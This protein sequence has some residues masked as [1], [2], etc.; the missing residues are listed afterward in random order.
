[1]ALKDLKR[2]TT[3][4]IGTSLDSEW[5]SN[6]NSDNFLGLK[7]NRIYYN[8]L[9]SNLDEIWKRFLYLHLLTNSTHGE[10]FK[11]Q[12]RNFLTR[13]ESSN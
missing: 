4:N 2:G 9:T 11:V 7:F 3:F 13:V 12:S 10:E 5:I 1:V 8:F 6:E